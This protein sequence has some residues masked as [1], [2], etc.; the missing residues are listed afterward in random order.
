LSRFFVIHVMILPAALMGLA[1]L[2]LFF[3]RSA[4]PAGPFRGTT[5]ELKAKTDFFF[6]RQVWK[7]IV[8]MAAVFM[9]ICTLAFIEP[10][11]L[12]EQATPDPGEYHPEPEWYFLFLF[13]MLRW[14]IFSG[15]FGQFLGAIA[16]PGLFL[17]LLAALPFIDR[18]PERNIFKRPIAL[19]SWTVV[20]IGIVVLT[21]SAILNREFLD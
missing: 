19:L 11:Q 13:Q 16:I 8:A 14:K 15:E 21:V 4:G 2:H 10:V 5:E 12:L 3:F 17:L 7:D 18:S 6:P 20:M 1:G 9:I